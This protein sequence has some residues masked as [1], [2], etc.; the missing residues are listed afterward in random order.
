MEAS[1]LCEM[2]YGFMGQG[3]GA[4]Q[5]HKFPPPEQVIPV[6]EEVAVSPKSKGMDNVPDPPVPANDMK[7]DSQCFQAEGKDIMRALVKDKVGL[8]K[9]CLI[10]VAELPFLAGVHQ[11]L[12]RARRYYGS[13]CSVERVARGQ[14][15][16]Q[17]AV[18]E[19]LA[20]SDFTTDGMILPMLEECIANIFS[21]EL[22]GINWQRP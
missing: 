4:E 16:P 8:G 10:D 9:L 11:C 21:R 2:I 5:Q 3:Q 19:L 22:D 14:V 15:D 20:L 12:C 6:E 7:L 13:S 1:A 18:A 17:A